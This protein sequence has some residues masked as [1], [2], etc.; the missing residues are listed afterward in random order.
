MPRRILI[1]CKGNICRSPMAVAMLRPHLTDAH[2][3]SAG[4]AAMQGYRVDPAAERTLRAHGLSAGDH[5]ARQLSSADLDNAELVLAMEKRQVTALLA[6]SPALR[7]RVYLLSRW[8]GDRDIRDP[9]GRTQE[10]FDIA[11]GQIDAAIGEWR[12]RL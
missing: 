12:S 3:D 7:G 2:I 6:L 5:V 4:L 1:V 8:S 9:Y 11:Y 10:N